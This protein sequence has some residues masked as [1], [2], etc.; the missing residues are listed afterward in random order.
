MLSFAVIVVLQYLSVST[1]NIWGCKHYTGTL[2][3]WKSKTKTFGNHCFR[4]N[5]TVWRKGSWN[6][7]LHFLYKVVAVLNVAYR[8]TH[9]AFS[10]CLKEKQLDPQVLT[11][12]HGHLTCR[13][14]SA[15]QNSQYD[16]YEVEVD[17]IINMSFK[18]WTNKVEYIQTNVIYNYL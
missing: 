14:G 15:D 2:L 17:A 18:V 8:Q 11:R 4:G 5:C 6:Q 9:T 3:F 16:I 10:F 12:N 1:K 13:R 7:T